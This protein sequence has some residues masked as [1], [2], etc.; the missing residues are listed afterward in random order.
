[1]RKLATLAVLTM[2]AG[3]VLA[4]GATAAHAGVHVGDF[5]AGT[6]GVPD[7]SSLNFINTFCGPPWEWTG[8]G[9][10]DNPYGPPFAE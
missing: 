6:A 10:C 3:T 4:G 8:H 2:S 1:M 7:P 5:L 9:E